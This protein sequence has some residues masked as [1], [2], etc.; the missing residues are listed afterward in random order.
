MKKFMKKAIAIATT[1]VMMII[2]VINEVKIN[3]TSIPVSSLMLLEASAANL[4]VKYKAHCADIGWQSGWKS[5]GAT[6]GTVGQSRKLECLK[7]SLSGARASDK[8]SVQTHLADIGWGNWTS[9]SNS[10]QLT[11]GTTGQSRAI[12]AIRIKLSGKIT[13]QYDIFY[14]VHVQDIG[15]MSWVKNG[16]TAGTTGRAL[17]T[18]AIQIKLEPKAT[19]YKTI[20]LGKFSTIEQW[21]K[22]VQKAEQ[23]AVGL[24]KYI[25]DYNGNIRNYGTMIVGTEAV[26]SK[27]MSIYNP[28][29]GRKQNFKFPTKIRFKLHKHSTQQTVWFDFTNLSVTQYCSCGESY[30]YTWEVPYP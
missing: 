19:S 27:T 28:Q 4:T 8:I 9:A 20:S 16:A 26:E 5:N 23:K 10:K 11:S 3:G 17:R 18:E 29:T 12:E 24:G 14:R 6:A 1:A 30:R 7:I 22:E 21:K 2:P 25:L 15:W 13:E